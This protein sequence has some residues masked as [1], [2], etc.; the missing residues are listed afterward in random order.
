MVLEYM[1][2][3]FQFL[4]APMS[5]ANGARECERRGG[6]LA[7]IIDESTN[8]LLVDQALF[9][10]NNKFVGEDTAW[11]IGGYDDDNNE[12]SWYW[13]DKTRMIFEAWQAI[14]PSQNG[15]DCVEMR[16]ENGYQY[17][18]NDRPCSEGRR[19][20]CQIGIP[21]CGDPGE[22]LHGNRL[23]D[24]RT[25]YS[26]NATL[27]FSC[28]EGYTLS[29][30]SVLRCMNNGA[31]N[32]QRPSCEAVECVNWPQGVALASTMTQGSVYQEIAVYTC[33][34]GYIPDNEPISFCQ[35]TGTWSTPNFTCS[36]PNLDLPMP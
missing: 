30:E 4:D 2:T 18:W 12:R 25:T 9:L 14:Q 16:F 15:H 36:A 29:G 28:Q 7:E 10:R 23:P 26:V 5:C 3:C 21:A 33:Q 31:W 20:L 34:D 35:H 13:S 8:A 19:A 32:H 6:F 22:P 11:L 1:T 24:D 17:E 27:H